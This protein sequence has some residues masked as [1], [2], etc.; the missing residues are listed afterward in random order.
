MKKINK[1]TSTR[2]HSITPDFVCLPNSILKDPPVH[3]THTPARCCFLTPAQWSVA[4]AVLVKARDAWVQ[5]RSRRSFIAGMRGIEHEKE[6]DAR[7]RAEWE[8]VKAAR[9]QGYKRE[10]PLRH[11]SFGSHGERDNLRSTFN[12]LE[13][14]VAFIVAGSRFNKREYKKL[15]RK[16]APEV[17][18]IE[19]SP[20]EILKLT[21]RHHNARKLRA[22]ESVLDRLTQPIAAGR[23]QGSFQHPS[24]LVAW[25]KL[26]DGKLS[27]LVDSG[28]WL[29]HEK[30]GQVP[31][32]LPTKSPSGLALFMF[33]HFINPDEEPRRGIEPQKLFDR[34]GIRRRNAAR[35]LDRALEVTNDHDPSLFDAEGNRIGRYVIRQRSDGTL[36]FRKDIVQAQDD[37]NED[38]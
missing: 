8:E 23:E 30:Y 26:P 21:G 34:L 4:C 29:P 7:Y 12:P 11:H 35:Y 13:P 17:V 9:K 22:V 14:R 5:E 38:T 33:L 32:P 24:V 2:K 19:L 15:T 25:C 28:Y 36:V 37:N 10:A 27:L 18:T 16:P 31:M 3:H 20:Y 1:N 6:D